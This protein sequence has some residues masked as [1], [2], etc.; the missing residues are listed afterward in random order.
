MKAIWQYEVTWRDRP[1]KVGS[2]S[3]GG[4]SPTRADARKAVQAAK[5]MFPLGRFNLQPPT[6]RVWPVAVKQERPSLKV[7]VNQAKLPSVAQV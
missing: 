5:S 7:V 3:V 6:G 2:T 1:P 4:T